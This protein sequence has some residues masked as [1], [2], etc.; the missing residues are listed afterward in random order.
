MKTCGNLRRDGTC[1]HLEGPGNPLFK[2]VGSKCM[3]CLNNM[4]EICDKYKGAP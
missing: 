2:V 3:L 1:K 4:A